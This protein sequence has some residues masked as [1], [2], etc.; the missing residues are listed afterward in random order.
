MGIEKMI[1]ILR[2]IK[3]NVTTKLL[4]DVSIARQSNSVGTKFI[5]ITLQINRWCVISLAQYIEVTYRSIGCFL[6]ELSH[7]LL[8]TC[9]RMYVAYVTIINNF[10]SY[11][12]I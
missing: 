1:N 6:Y 4:L 11:L 3:Q 5:C 12:Y 8:Y 9:T 10:L 7:I 2:R